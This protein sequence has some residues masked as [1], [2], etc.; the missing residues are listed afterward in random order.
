MILPATNT[1]QASEPA[2]AVNDSTGNDTHLLQD[3][4]KTELLELLFQLS[5][6]PSKEEFLFRNVDSALL[7]YFSGRILTLL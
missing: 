4:T 6:T 3:P 2:A 1:L 5:I 7:I